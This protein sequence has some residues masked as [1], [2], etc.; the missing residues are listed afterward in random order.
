[1]RVP[2]RTLSGA[3]RALDVPPHFFFE[4]ARE[5]NPPADL[6][7]RR[8]WVAALARIKDPDLRKAVI[9][10]ADNLAQMSY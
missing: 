4:T 6:Q 3:C 7:E 5:P 10:L 8:E 9:R 2:A 1:M